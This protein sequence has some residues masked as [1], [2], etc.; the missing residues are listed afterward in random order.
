MTTRKLGDVIYLDDGDYIVTGIQ[1]DN[2]KF[3]GYT[4]ERK[5][6]VWEDVTWNSAI[7]ALMEDKVDVRCRINSDR[8]WDNVI[9]GD[10]GDALYCDSLKIV[11]IFITMQW[12]V[13]RFWRSKE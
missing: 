13:R 4:I 5:P 11:P 10:A 1:Y 9:K 2:W 12:Q 3:T 8:P 7:A 6:E